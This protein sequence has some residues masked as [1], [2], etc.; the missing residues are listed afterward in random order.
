[1]EIFRAY[2]IRGV[3]PGQLS[4]ELA[5][6]IGKAFAAFLGK[7]SP[8]IA[9]GMDARNSGPELK[10]AVIRGLVSAGARVLDIG[11]VPTPMVYFAVAHK[12]LDGGI[13]VTASHNPPEYNG[14]KF[15]IKGGVSI[16]WDEGLE[17]VKE[18]AEKGEFREGKGSAEKVSLDEEYVKFC[19]GKARPGKKMKV[20][21]DCGNGSAGRVARRLLETAGVDVVGLYCEPDGNFPNHQP[22]PLKKEN[23]KDLQEKVRE[24]GADIGIAY[25]GDGDRMG[26]VDEKGGIVES[27]KVF[28]MFIED[29]LRAEPGAKIVYEVLVSDIIPETIEKLGGEKVLSKVGHTYIQDAMVKKGCR[30]GGENSGHYFFRE[31]FSYDDGVYASLK[32]LSLIKGKVSEQAGKFPAYMESRQYRPKCPDSRKFRVVEELKE[33][34]EKKY[35]VIGLD[36]VK[37]V[38]DDGWFIV[39]ASNT[40]P[41]LVVRW[42]AKT[43]EAFQRIGK[44]VREELAGVGIALE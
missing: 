26:V 17:K 14:M 31:N 43:R 18:L 34:L 20:V 7:E 3:Y 41:E 4:R 30:L 15:C 24:S 38:L 33:R 11:L 29:A 37:A 27:S 16:G 1:M 8:R 6:R 42:E 32:F 22:D 2:D 44:T 21:I 25:D 12:G 13:M 9:V 19:L 40:A 5:E 36:G 39:R 10:E 28:S 23:L 35:K